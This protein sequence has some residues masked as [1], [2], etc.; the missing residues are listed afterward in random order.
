MWD[1]VLHWKL[2]F[3][4]LVHNGKERPYNAWAENTNVWGKCFF[5][6]HKQLFSQAVHAQL[7]SRVFFFFLA[8]VH[9]IH[10]TQSFLF[11][12]YPPPQQDAHWRHFLL[13]AGRFSRFFM[14]ETL[15]RQR[16]VWL[17]KVSGDNTES[18]HKFQPLSIGYA[19]AFSTT[20]EMWLIVG[21]SGWS[22]LN[23]NHSDQT[24]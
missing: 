1:S 7:D 13:E 11:I 20:K 5:L 3:C 23:S 12:Y 10:L 14:E 17:E 22:G 24:S 4:K 19:A 15:L 2:Q 21:I 9:G 6:V 16:V 18:F 8:L